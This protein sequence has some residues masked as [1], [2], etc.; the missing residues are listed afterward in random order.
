L[1][2]FNSIRVQK[3]ISADAAI[4]W[5]VR[6]GSNARAVT[7]TSAA[8]LWRSAFLTAIGPNF[9]PVVFSRVDQPLQKA[10]VQRRSKKKKK[11][12]SN[13]NNKEDAG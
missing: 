5:F 13:P 8:A 12:G 3:K 4:Y 7:G 9:P 10:V 6:C 1:K 2:S 11:G